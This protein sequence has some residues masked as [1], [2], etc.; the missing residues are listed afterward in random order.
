LARRRTWKMPS[1]PRKP[2]TLKALS[3]LGA[4]ESKHAKRIVGLADTSQRPQPKP[5]P[6]SQTSDKGA[7]QLYH[8]VCGR[9]GTPREQTINK[10]CAFYLKTKC[11]GELMR[12]TR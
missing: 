1:R 7:P 5:Y 10:V 2:I 11:L 6:L 12:S 4:L 9:C 8:V 3:S